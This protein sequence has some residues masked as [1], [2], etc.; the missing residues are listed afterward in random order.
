MTFIFILFFYPFI[1]VFFPVPFDFLRPSDFYFYFLFFL[2]YFLFLQ[3]KCFPL[4]CTVSIRL[5]FSDIRRSWL[6]IVTDIIFCIHGISLLN[7]IKDQNLEIWRK[8][9]HSERK[10][11]KSPASTRLSIL[12]A[13][14]SIFLC[15][16]SLLT[17]HA[18]THIS[19]ILQRHSRGGEKLSRHYT[20]NISGA[21]AASEMWGKRGC[22][23][24]RGGAEWK[25]GEEEEEETN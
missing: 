10:K 24:R 8:R 6:R 1:F 11:N 19:F 4:L 22:E 12:P 7:K 16:P 3:M 9:K 2:K 17:F 18:V 23:W 25:E 14:E 5:R 15:L 20:F 21:S 13:S